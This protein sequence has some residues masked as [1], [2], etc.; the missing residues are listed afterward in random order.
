MRPT[1][2]RRH[3][4]GAVDMAAGDDVETEGPPGD[5]EKPLH[6]TLAGDRSLQNRTIEI[7]GGN[8]RNALRGEKVRTNGFRSKLEKDHQCILG[9]HPLH[10]SAPI[11]AA[12]GREREAGEVSHYPPDGSVIELGRTTDHPFPVRWERHLDP[13][14]AENR[15]GEPP[16]GGR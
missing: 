11:V 7:G 10:G 13:L 2:P 9:A 12:L 8:R 14:P 16:E 6:T 5:R 4:V 1:R 3:D 15:H